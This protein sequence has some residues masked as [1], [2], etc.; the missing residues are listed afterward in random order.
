MPKISNIELSENN[1]IYFKNNNTELLEEIKKQILKILDDFCIH[2]SVPDNIKNEMKKVIL[3]AIVRKKINYWMQD[4][5]SYL[6]DKFSTIL[7]SD[8]ESENVIEASDLYKK[9]V[10]YI[11]NTKHTITYE[12]ESR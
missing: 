4:K 12:P 6:S 5:C 8:F 2:E 11:K 7:Q 3:S 9:D 1:P 10:Y